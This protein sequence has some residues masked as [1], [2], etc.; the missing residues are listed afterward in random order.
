MRP[1]PAV[2]SRRLVMAD[3]VSI[4]I[5]DHAKRYSIYD[6]PRALWA[7]Q[8]WS[9]HS[10]LTSWKASGRFTFVYEVYML[11]M[12]PGAMAA[13]IASRYKT[14]PRLDTYS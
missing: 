3:G 11:Y 9:L 4:T 1:V 2:A 14:G 10:R 12:L 7:S 6:T 8:R 5:L 13:G